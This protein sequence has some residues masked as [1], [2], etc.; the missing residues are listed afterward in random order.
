METKTS[1][2]GSPLTDYRMLFNGI[3]DPI[4]IYRVSDTREFDGFM[5]ANEAF[6]QRYGIPLHKVSRMDFSHITGEST[7]ETVDLL[8]K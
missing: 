8:V 4:L 3:L 1:Q 7:L 5:L 2:G 6:S